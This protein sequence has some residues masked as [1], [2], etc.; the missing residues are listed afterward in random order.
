MGFGGLLGLDKFMGAGL[1]SNGISALMG[2][3]IR[4][5]ALSLPVLP[6][7]GPVSLAGNDSSLQPRA[8]ASE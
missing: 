7:R 5:L 6:R 2:R 8:E 3:D 1:S 4:E